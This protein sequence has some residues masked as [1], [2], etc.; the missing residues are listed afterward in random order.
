MPRYHVRISTPS[1]TIFR[2]GEG[3]PEDVLYLS[4]EWVL[5]REMWFIDCVTPKTIFTNQFFTQK[6]LAR[7]F[8]KV[9]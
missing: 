3:K 5:F 9:Q 7:D 1:V 2:Q 8:Y 6:F 4:C